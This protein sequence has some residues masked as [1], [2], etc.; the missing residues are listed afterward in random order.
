MSENE[1]RDWLLYFGCVAFG[2]TWVALAV[3]TLIGHPTDTADLLVSSGTFVGIYVLIW[4]GRVVYLA[5]KRKKAGRE[6]ESH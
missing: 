3:N 5:I 2:S 4:V 6:N 1:K